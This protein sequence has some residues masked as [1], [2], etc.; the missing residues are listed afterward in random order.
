MKF[1][2]WAPWKVTRPWLPRAWLGTDEYHNP[3][4]SVVLP[5]LGAF[6]VWFRNWRDDTGGHYSLSPEMDAP[7]CPV[8]LHHRDTYDAL[9][10]GW[11]WNPP[12]P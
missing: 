7:N 5:L 4:V 10:R 12:R 8:C 2:W 9:P 11:W 3:A 1:G 6:H